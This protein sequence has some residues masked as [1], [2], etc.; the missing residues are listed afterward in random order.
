MNSTPSGKAAFPAV[1][2]PVVG[3]DHDM[4]D[5]LVGDLPD[6]LH[7]PGGFVETP[8][9]V[10]DQHAVARDHEHAHGG[11]E[12]FAGGPELLVGIHARREF[13]DPGEVRF[14]QPPLERVGGAGRNFG[15]FGG[16]LGGT[17]RFGVRRPER[18]P[19]RRRR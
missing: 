6:L 12:L 9:P 3:R 14:G 16:S 7:H 13:L 5:G 11:E 15:S 1:W 4:G 10:G 18:V 19:G 2:S 8:L 17:L